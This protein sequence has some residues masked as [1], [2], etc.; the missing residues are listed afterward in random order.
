MRGKGGSSKAGW[1]IP[2]LV[3]LQ[4]KGGRDLLEEKT[5]WDASTYWGEVSKK[6]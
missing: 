5:D 2:L 6:R 3:S 4:E 1:E